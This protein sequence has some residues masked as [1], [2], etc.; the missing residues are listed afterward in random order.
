M[1]K[2]SA[3][4]DTMPKAWEG[5]KRWKG[6]KKPVALVATVVQIKTAVQLLSALEVNSP[7]MTMNPA[8]IPIKLNSTC[9]NVNNVIPKII[10]PSLN[11][12]TSGSPGERYHTRAG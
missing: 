12:R 11:Q 2:A 10:Q 9:T 5:K 1:A 4:R 6:N 8:K 7:S 3:T